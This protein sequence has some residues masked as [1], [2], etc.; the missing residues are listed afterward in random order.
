MFTECMQMLEVPPFVKISPRLW[1]NRCGALNTTSQK[2]YKQKNPYLISRSIVNSSSRVM[3]TDI[4]DAKDILNDSQQG[5][6]LI[7]HLITSQVVSMDSNDTVL[8]TNVLV[9]KF[10]GNEKVKCK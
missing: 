7:I 3:Q 5:E 1:G 6:K 2:T 4:S 9:A 8:H 10:A